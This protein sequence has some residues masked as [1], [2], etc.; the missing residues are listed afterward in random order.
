MI[1]ERRGWKLSAEMSD[2]LVVARA[3]R[4]VRDPPTH[5]H[6]PEPGQASGVAR[7]ITWGC[8]FLFGAHAAPL[9]LTLVT[10]A[11]SPVS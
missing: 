4:M 3:V 5:E 6:D 9:H 2:E 10:P 7:S 8:E 11:R 1:L